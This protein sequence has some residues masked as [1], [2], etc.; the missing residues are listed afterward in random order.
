MSY[1][2]KTYHENIVCNDNRSNAE[3]RSVSHQPRTK[4]GGKYQVDAND[5][6]NLFC[7]VIVKHIR[8]S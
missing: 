6:E 4:F 5:S 1:S 2:L 7:V 8:L 3:R